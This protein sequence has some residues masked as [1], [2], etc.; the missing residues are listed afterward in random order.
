MD[1]DRDAGKDVLALT[2]D[3][4]PSEWT[5]RIM[6]LLAEH[7]ARAT[8]FVLGDSIEGGEP[9]LQRALAEGHELGLHGW[10]H[11]H[12]PELPDAEIR[13]EMLRTQ[14]AIE[15]AT[16]FRAHFWRPPYF[17]ADERVRLALAEM[18][19]SEV[20]CTVAPEDWHWPAARTAAYVIE[21]LRSGAVIDLHD[22]RPE[23]SGSDQT[24][25]AT[26]SALELILTAMKARNLR[27]VPISEISD[28]PLAKGI[29]A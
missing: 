16:G 7:D 24:R 18:D 4:G 22:G 19:L 6:D 20:G 28:A 29:S 1:S 10:S 25:L 11:R 14:A 5:P 23:H 21:R 3:D 8:F 26:L 15:R 13:S 9:T 17:E 2:F 27:S 12:L